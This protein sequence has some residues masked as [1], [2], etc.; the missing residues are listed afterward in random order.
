M[1]PHV[2]ELAILRADDGWRLVGGD[3][4]L[5]RFPYRVDAEEAALRLIERARLDHQ[6][7]RLLVQD[8]AG[9]LRPFRT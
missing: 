6:E 9:Q 5:G 1:P 2:T 7:V 3:R 8:E 4:T